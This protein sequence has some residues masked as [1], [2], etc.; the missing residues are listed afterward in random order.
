ME[1]VPCWVSLFCGFNKIQYNF[2]SSYTRCHHH[3]VDVVVQYSEHIPM[4]TPK[5]R[6]RL[7]FYLQ[8]STNVQRRGGNHH[9]LVINETSETKIY[10]HRQNESLWNSSW[11]NH[12]NT[13]QHTMFRSRC[14]IQCG[15]CDVS[16]L[17]CANWEFVLTQL[18]SSPPHHQWTSD[19]L[20]QHHN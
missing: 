16:Q 2:I 9:S 8:L 14:N 19:E 11:H 4:H 6:L 7:N 5:R 12:D 15:S 17:E 18:S 1:F 10:F 20:T 3:R 13:M